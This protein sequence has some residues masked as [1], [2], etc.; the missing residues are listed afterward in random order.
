MLENCSQMSINNDDG[1]DNSFFDD[2]PG[3]GLNNSVDFHFGF[4]LCVDNGLFFTI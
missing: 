2:V 3:F 1:N 4:H